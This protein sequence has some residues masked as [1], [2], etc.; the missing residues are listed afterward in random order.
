MIRFFSCFFAFFF[1]FAT[2]DAAWSA[3]PQQMAAPTV[4]GSTASLRPP[5]PQQKTI[6]MAAPA[7]PEDGSGNR[8]KKEN[9]WLDPAALSAFAL[10]LITFFLWKSTQT[11]AVATQ[12]TATATKNVAESTNALALATNSL[13]S[14]TQELAAYTRALAEEAASSSKIKMRAYVYPAGISQTSVANN[15]AGQTGGPFWRLSVFVE[16]HGE[17][18]TRHATIEAH[19]KCL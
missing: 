16:N 15:V 18:P 2:S 14:H 17:T 9:Q 6:Q 10:A 3:D 13:A 11:A 8:E 1:L 19:A 12:N 4:E 7:E 5:S